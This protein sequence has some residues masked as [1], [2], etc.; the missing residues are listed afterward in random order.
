M[1]LILEG[2]NLPKDG[3]WLSIII[4]PSKDVIVD[5]LRYGDFA[6]LGTEYGSAI[7]IPKDHGRIGDLDALENT[8]NYDLLHRDKD[9]G[10]S[11]KS[12]W[13][14]IQDAPTILEAERED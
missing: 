1:S 14:Y 10:F 11:T 13:S 4:K 2:I 12:I 5:T 3:E 9:D 8:I 6:V 7:Q